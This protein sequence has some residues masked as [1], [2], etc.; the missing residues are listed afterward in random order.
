MNIIIGDTLLNYKTDRNKYIIT[1]IEDYNPV[2]DTYIDKIFDGIFP[3]YS[4][5]K[6]LYSN[7]CGDNAQFICNN[8]KIDGVILG[9]IIIIDWV[10]KNPEIILKIDSVYGPLRNTIGAS[11]HALAYL[12]ITIEDIQY[13]IAIETTR[14]VP[15]KLQFYVGTNKE[16]FD[17]VIKTCYQCNNFIISFDCNKRWYEIAYSGGKKR[18]TKQKR[19]RKIKTKNRRLNKKN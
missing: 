2:L 18:K 8:L 17:T 12:E 3:H 6:L 19:K 5:N 9:I 1:Y 11:Y 16:E 7:V 15:Y 13:Y 10:K 14:C 4:T